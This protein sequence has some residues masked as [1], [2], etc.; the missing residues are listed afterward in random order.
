MKFQR[1]MMYFLLLNVQQLEKCEYILQ[2]L[3][4]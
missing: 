4:I 2:L 1:T 3:P